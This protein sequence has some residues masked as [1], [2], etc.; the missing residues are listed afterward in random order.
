MFE[1]ARSNDEAAFKKLEVYAMSKEP[2]MRQMAAI[3]LG[4]SAHKDSFNLLMT[5]LYDENNYVRGAAAMGLGFKGD[6]RAYDALIE[7]LD[8]DESSEVKGRAVFALGHL[9]TEKAL[10][11]IIEC[12]KSNLVS[13]RK[14]AAAVL[15]RAEDTKVIEPLIDALRDPEDEVRQNA[16][17]SL[18]RLTGQEAIYGMM[19]A[20]SIEE[21]QRMWRE[22]WVKNGPTFKVQSRK[23]GVPASAKEWMEKYDADKNGSLDEKELQN[24]L[25][26]MMKPKDFLKKGDKL[27]TDVTLTGMDGA[28]AKLAERV[29]GT[30]LIYY[31]HSSCPYC[32]NAEQFVKKLY[33]D[34][35]AKKITLIGIASSRD[36][37]DD[38]KSYVGKT[39]FSFPVMWDDT[40][41]FSG[42]N[43]IAATPSVIIIDKSGTVLEY[44]R[45]L[46]ESAREALAKRVAEL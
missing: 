34:C 35:A 25:D 46:P 17:K 5:L 13:V 32:L 30:T 37:L 26:E 31:F 7:A 21:G 16:A 2:E 45:G 42:R 43:Q 27:K 36:K 15:G 1:L 19:W 12:L 3:A 33:A 10:P 24:S 20:Q 14:N 23:R 38:L 18:R 29:N 44:Q 22:W 11:K 4:Q 9:K 28:K 40:Q 39:G 8:K 6:E 41:E